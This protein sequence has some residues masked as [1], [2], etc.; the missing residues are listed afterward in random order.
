MIEKLSLTELQL[1]IRDS[2]YLAFPEMYWVIAEI[3]EI[4]ENSSGHCYLELIEKHPEEDNIKARIKAIIWSKRYGFL[5]S[6]FENITGE[7]LREGLK[8]LIKIKIEYHEVYGLSLV[9][10]DIDPGFT[11]GEMAMKRQQIVKKLEQEGVFS[12]NKELEFPDFPQRIAIISS[13]NAAGYSDFIN[14]LKGNSFGYSFYTELIESAMQGVETEPG[15]INALDKI[16]LRAHLFD[17]VVIIRGGGSQT[18]LSW[19]DSYN[20]AY[21]IT[22]FPLPVITGI[23]HDKD[24]SVTDMVASRYLKTP[25]AVADY[26]IDCMAFAENRIVDMSSRIRDISQII[27]EQNRNLVQTYKTKLLPLAHILMSEIKELLSA[28]I[29]EIVTYGKEQT[30]RAGLVHVNHRSRLV[31]GVKSFFSGK[32]IKMDRTC[33]LLKSCTLNTI[34]RNRIMLDGLGNTLNIMKP[35]NVLQRGYTITSI[36]GR[37]LKN[38]ARLKAGDLID[39]QFSDGAVSSRVLRNNGQGGDRETGGKI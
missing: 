11:I 24:M 39:T 28:K 37:I 21:H 13:K 23:G 16:A 25:T 7:S 26:L 29:I 17:L 32:Y 12:M 2:L 19:F 4:K 1:I 10:T 20:I 34:D 33:Q 6:F 27:I 22:Q 3:S 5:R 30:F 14:Q 36:D 35:E 8:I 18:D 9:I 15:V 31:S 38:S